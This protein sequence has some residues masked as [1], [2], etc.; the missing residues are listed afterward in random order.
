MVG[1][2]FLA[3]NCENHFMAC[4]LWLRR[5]VSNGVAKAVGLFPFV[6]LYFR[7]C[8]STEGSV[9]ERA[10]IVYWNNKITFEF[11]IQNCKNIM[12]GLGGLV[13]CCVDWAAWFVVVWIGRP[14]LHLSSN[15]FRI[16]SLQNVKI[17]RMVGI[18]ER[19]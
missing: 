5:C 16:I 14:G 13:C 9:A 19:E 8:V 6:G 1:F 12:N 3:Q 17:N 10:I 7:R 11:L 4:E 18:V 15:G 2:E